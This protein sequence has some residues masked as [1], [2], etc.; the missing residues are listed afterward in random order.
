MVH[1]NHFY[2]MIGIKVNDVE[3]DDMS[4]FSFNQGCN[5][6]TYV[7]REYH[8]YLKYCSD[9]KQNYN[10]SDRFEGKDG[11]FQINALDSQG[12]DI[13]AVAKQEASHELEPY[14]SNPQIFNLIIQGQ[15]A[16]LIIPSSDQIEE[17]NH[18][19]E[20]IVR[21]PTPIEIDGGRYNYFLL[22]ADKEHIQDIAKT[23]RFT[24]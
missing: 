16:R 24:V 19:A 12:R 4:Y 23:I 15:E 21:Y 1:D 2:D 3:V 13:D 9:W 8:I 5:L 11:F 18:Q 22:Y 14:G 7:N 20:V 6:A 10:Y 17:M